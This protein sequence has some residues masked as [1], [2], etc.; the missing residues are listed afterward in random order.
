MQGKIFFQVFI[1]LKW[2]DFTKD[3]L[4]YGFYKPYLWL[5]GVFYISVHGKE[6]EFFN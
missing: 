2:D 4:K 5:F 6:V 3:V 1:Y